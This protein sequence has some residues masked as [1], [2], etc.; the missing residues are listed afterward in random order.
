VG[1]Q[2]KTFR[3][4]VDTEIK[5]SVINLFGKRQKIIKIKSNFDGQPLDVLFFTQKQVI[6]NTDLFNEHNLSSFQV[7]TACDKPINKMIQPLPPP[8]FFIFPKF[9]CDQP[10]N[11]MI[12]PLIISSFLIKEEV[13]K[14]NIDKIS[15]IL[16]ENV[17]I[18]SRTNLLDYDFDIINK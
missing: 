5:F 13:I 9:S 8:S 4:P 16:D 10:M 12:Q 18:Y 7:K 3:I 6:V 15:D 17:S 14:E 2:K 1:L 11:T